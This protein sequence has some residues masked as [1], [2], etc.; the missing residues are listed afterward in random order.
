MLQSWV[1]EILIVYASVYSRKLNAR[2]LHFYFSLK[3]FSVFMTEFIVSSV[4]LP[5]YHM[6]C[7]LLQAESDC[8]A[9]HD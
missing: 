8:S 5:R 4:T 7:D 3:F 6:W 1:V 2:F 9:Y